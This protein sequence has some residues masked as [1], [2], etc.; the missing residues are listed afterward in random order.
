ML[1]QMGVL[2]SFSIAKKV[3]EADITA[4][5]KKNK[6]AGKTEEQIGELLKEK[7]FGEIRDA[8]VNQKVPGLVT[9]F[10]IM[11]PNVEAGITKNLAELNRLLMIISHKLIEKKF[12]KL[13]L[14]YFIN[15]LV[16]LIGLTEKDFE[17]FHR[18]MSNQNNDEEDDD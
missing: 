6:K 12:D 10:D 18:K 17:N 1:T 13:S 2:T 3:T 4:F 15:S 5:F 8:L 7:I 14:C 9:P 16:N 11:N